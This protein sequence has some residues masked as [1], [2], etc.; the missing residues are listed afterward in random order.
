MSGNHHHHD[1]SHGGHAHGSGRTLMLAVLVTISFAVVEAVGGWL[2]GSLALLSDAGHMVTDASALAI[3]DVAAWLTRRPASRRMSFGFQRAEVLGALLNTLLMGLVV[4]AVT[5][6]ALRRLAEPVP[7]AGM[8]VMVVAAIGLG[9]SS[10]GARE[11][12]EHR[13]RFSRT[14]LAVTQNRLGN[15]RQNRLG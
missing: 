9:V 6:T 1:H 5:V 12:P 4:V 10:I 8:M 15:A 3:G 14:G 13:M 7:V 2:S 11:I